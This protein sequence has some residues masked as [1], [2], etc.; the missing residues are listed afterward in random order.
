MLMNLIKIRRGPALCM[1][2]ICPPS[3]AAVTVHPAAVPV[4][5][6]PQGSASSEPPLAELKGSTS[7]K[8][9]RIQ[10]RNDQ[11][12]RLFALP[13][14]EVCA[15]APLLWRWPGLRVKA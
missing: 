9:R 3:S 8:L 2:A 5:T 4:P 7:T 6:P 12:R 13:A 10:Q 11:L 14:T 1:P 15:S